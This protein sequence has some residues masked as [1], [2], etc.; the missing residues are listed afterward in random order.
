MRRRRRGR[1]LTEGSGGASGRAS[2]APS[3]EGQSGTWRRRAS[4]VHQSQVLVEWAGGA[5]RVSLPAPAED[6]G[7]FLSTPVRTKRIRLPAELGGVSKL[8]SPGTPVSRKVLPSLRMK[9]PEEQET[10][11][12]ISTLSL[13]PLTTLTEIKRSKKKTVHST[14]GELSMSGSVPAL[15]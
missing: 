15:R 5:M 8:Q 7:T 1:R 3:A 12:K 6:P 9:L 11:R 2:R 14:R 4:S 10:A 13:M